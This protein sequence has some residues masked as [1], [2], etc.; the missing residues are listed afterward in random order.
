MAMTINTNTASLNAQRNT[1]TNTASLSTTMARLSSGLRVNS[2]KD[3]AAGLAIADRMNT[4][5]RGMNVAI[6][7]A[8]DGISMAQVAEGGLSGINDMLQR[9]R[10]LAVQASNSTNQSSDIAKLDKEYQELGKEVTRMIDAT[11]FNGDSILKTTA[12]YVFQVGANTGTENQ[13]TIGSAALATNVA[14][15]TAVT[16]GGGSSALNSAAS[17]NTAVI[18]ALDNALTV[19]ND[20]RANLGAVQSRFENTISYLRTAVENQSA[21]RGRIMDADFAAETANLSRTQILQQAGTA[22]IAQA[23]QLPQNVLK[24][25]QG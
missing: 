11:Q 13:I 10:E 14:N 8:S 1:A 25:L 12:S 3:D 23:N 15:L 5:V 2:A 16:N 4:Q 18:A 22:M 9:M 19:V 24:L 6:R 17:A 7:N 21:A 20:N